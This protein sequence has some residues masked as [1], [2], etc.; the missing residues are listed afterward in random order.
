M[1][2]EEITLFGINHK[3]KPQPKQSRHTQH[4]IIKPEVGKCQVQSFIDL[5]QE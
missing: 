4:P 2:C 1:A 3:N 5:A